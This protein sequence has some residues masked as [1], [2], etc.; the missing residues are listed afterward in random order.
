MTLNKDATF[1]HLRIGFVFP[2]ARTNRGF[3]TTLRSIDAPLI[4][5]SGNPVLFVPGSTDL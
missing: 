2:G 4:T 5:R 1:L 3:S